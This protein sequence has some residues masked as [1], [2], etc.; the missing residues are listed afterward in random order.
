MKDLLQDGDILV[1]TSNRFIPRLI[2][3]ATKSK[4]THTAQIFSCW[5][6]LGVLEA[7]MGGVHWIPFDEWQ[8]KYGYE[9][10]VYRRRVINPK[11]LAQKA[12]SYLGHTAY[13]YHSFLIRQPLGLL[14]GRF[15]S[16]PLEKEEAKTICSE[17]TA[18]TEGWHRPETFTPDKVNKYCNRSTRY[19]LIPLNF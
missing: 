19:E 4:W 15:I 17:L 9:F 13:D 3:A 8:K 6:I 16:K 1:C 10:I 14:T 7:Q 2:K 12:F 18:R 11:E 5:G